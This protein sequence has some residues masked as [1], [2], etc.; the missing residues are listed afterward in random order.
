MTV[1][2]GEI[3]FATSGTTGPA[4]TW[5][6]TPGQLAAE[7]DLL[8]A[9]TVG[10]VDRVICFA[11]PHHLYGG[12]FGVMIPRTLGVPVVSAWPDPLTLPAPEPD[13]RTLLVC[14]PSTWSLLLRHTR[15]LAGCRSVLAVH[16]TARTTDATYEVAHRLRGT[17]FRGVEVLGSTETGAVAVRTVDADRRQDA[18]W[19]LLPDVR[20]APTGARPQAL[21]VGGPRLGRR[22]DMARR[23]RSWPMPDLVVP[24][25]ARRFRHVGRSTGLV[26]V[27]GVRCDLDQL[28]ALV[29]EHLPDVRVACVPV[30]DPVRGEHY[31]LYYDAPMPPAELRVRFAGIRGSAPAPRAVRRVAHLPT[32]GGTVRRDLSPGLVGTDRE[33]V[34]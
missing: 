24:T 15:T 9:S 11:P 7:A 17:G 21:R 5:L 22:R 1:P 34:R 19:E 23:P 30:T 33:A 2:T 18:E 31:D 27:N 32:T 26:K 28:E 4:V 14:L 20:W 6:R 16:S 29:R 10:E 25:G 13:E 3:A 8:I 12:I